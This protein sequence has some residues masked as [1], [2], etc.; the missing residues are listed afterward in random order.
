MFPVPE[1]LGIDLPIVAGDPAKVEG[2]T[3]K[4]SYFED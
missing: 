3:Y 4:R 2:Q 1:K